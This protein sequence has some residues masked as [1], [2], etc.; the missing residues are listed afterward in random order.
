MGGQC[1][2]CQ[3]YCWQQIR[4]D[5]DCCCWCKKFILPWEYKYKYVKI[6]AISKYIAN[7]KYAKIETAAA[8][9]RN[10]F[11]N[12]KIQMQIL[13]IYKFKFKNAKSETDSAECEIKS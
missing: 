12:A 4:K 9:V 10:S 8:D 2:V 1:E 5:W 13:S 7:S 6:L 3:G 11:N